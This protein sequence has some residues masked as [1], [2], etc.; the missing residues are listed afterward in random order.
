MSFSSPDCHLPSALKLAYSC[1]LCLCYVYPLLCSAVVSVL[2]HC[3]MVPNLICALR[4][5]CK[6]M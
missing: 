2:I 6:Y 5:C 1:V 4:F 3:G